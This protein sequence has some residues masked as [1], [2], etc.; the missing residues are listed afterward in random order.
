METPSRHEDPSS[1]RDDD[2]ALRA[3]LLRRDPLAPSDLAVAHLE[4]LVEWLG[5]AFPRRAFP[6]MDPDLLRIAATDL[7]LDL[8]ETPERYDPDRGDLPAYLRMAAKGDVLNALKREGRRAGRQVPLEDVELSGWARNSL[9]EGP[10]DPAEVVAGATRIDPE[11]MT[12]IRGHFDDVEWE[13][14]QLMGE[15]ERRTSRFALVLGLADWPE[16]E[17]RREVKKVK[18]RLQKR[19]RRLGLD[20]PRDD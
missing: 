15:R 9:V 4:P 18:D 1:R 12:T 7:I 3:R 20:V 14:V 10:P 2:R 11:T 13:V 16:I 5:R 8:A 17:Q 19:L 6:S